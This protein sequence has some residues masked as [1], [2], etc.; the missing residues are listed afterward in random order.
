MESVAPVSSTARKNLIP[1]FHDYP[2]NQVLLFG[3]APLFLVRELH[4]HPCSH[5][6]LGHPGQLPLLRI[7]PLRGSVIPLHCIAGQDR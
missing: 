5:E 2:E 6:G 4:I 3:A 1:D 7:I